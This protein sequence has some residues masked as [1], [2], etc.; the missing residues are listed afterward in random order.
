MKIGWM[1]GFGLGMAAGALVVHNCK[2][3]RQ[4]VAETQNAVVQKIEE[5]NKQ[6][7]ENAETGNS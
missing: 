6:M 3:A 1:I 5:K 7:F 4:K 2:K